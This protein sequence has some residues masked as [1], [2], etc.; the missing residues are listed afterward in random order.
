MTFVDR[1]LAPVDFSAPSFESASYAGALA[2]R[3][4]AR[5]TLLHVIDP[6]ALDYAMIGPTQQLVNEMTR[7]RETRRHE[8]LQQLVV[9]G[10]HVHRELAAGD[11]AEGILKHAHDARSNLIVMA[12][13]GA[14]PIQRV[15]GVG[16]VTLRVLG[17]A[18]CPVL[19]GTHFANV[20]A[21]D[22]GR[23]VCAL[24]LDAVEPPLHWARQAAEEF[25]AKLT[26]VHAIRFTDKGEMIDGEWVSTL[27]RR[28]KDRFADLLLTHRV[29][30]DVVIEEGSPREV[31]SNAARVLNAGLVVIGRSTGRDTL[32]RLRANSFDIIRRS[33]CPVVS[34]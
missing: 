29:D 1:M 30:A 21:I 34:V 18:E 12:T 4:G 3:V 27:R 26:I 15:L 24:D 33:P 8:Q 2:E 7:A 14:G 11:P 16:S 5:L 19:T 10:D 23:I 9:H 32:G 17:G 28:L 20:P 13:H 6:V 31:V 25:G 22:D